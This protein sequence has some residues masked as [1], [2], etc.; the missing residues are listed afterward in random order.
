MNKGVAAWSPDTVLPGW[1][2]YKLPITMPWLNAFIGVRITQWWAPSGAVCGRIKGM[3]LRGI[4]VSKHQWILLQS[5]SPLVHVMHR[6]HAWDIRE[7][8]GGTPEAI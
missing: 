8:L 1:Y 3:N 6:V 2:K 7:W 5:L 4:E